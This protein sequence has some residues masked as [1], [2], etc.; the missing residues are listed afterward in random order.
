VST[1]TQTCVTP[2]ITHTCVTPVVSE[3]CSHCDH[4]QWW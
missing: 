3:P 4:S 1:V 2:V